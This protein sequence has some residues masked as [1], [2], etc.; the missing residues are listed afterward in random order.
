MLEELVRELVV[1]LREQGLGRLGQE[2]RE[3]GSPRAG[4]NRAVSDEPVGPKGAEMLADAARRDPEG[5]GDL[6]GPGL[7]ALLEGEDHLPRRDAEACEGGLG[8][9]QHV[10][11]HRSMAGFGKLK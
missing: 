9:A 5:L 1:G 3:L 2:V 4:V 11:K 6:A 10:H 8:R 7:P